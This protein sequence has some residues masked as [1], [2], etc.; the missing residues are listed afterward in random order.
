MV[1]PKRVGT[2]AVHI[3]L[4]TL[5][6]DAP[7]SHHSKKERESKLATIILLCKRKLVPQYGC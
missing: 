3:E 7:F 4:Y 6:R 1:Y 2:T 5:K